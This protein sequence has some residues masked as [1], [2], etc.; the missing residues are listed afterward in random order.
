MTVSKKIA[1]TTVLMTLG[2]SSAALQV[3]A[4]DQV[5]TNGQVTFT[6]GGI[7]PEG[8]ATEPPTNPDQ[9]GEIITPESSPGGATGDGGPLSLDFAP[10]LDFD[11]RDISTKDATYFA[12]VQKG[13]NEAGESV[14]IPN[15][16]QVSDK[17]GTGAGWNLSVT[18]KGQ[19]VTGK[20]KELKGAEIFL[21]HPVIMSSI[22]D[23][24]LSPDITYQGTALFG[25]E[26]ALTP[27]MSADEDKGMGQFQIKFGTLL[28]SDIPELGDARES[29]ILK[30]PGSTVKYADTYTT[31][32]EWTLADIPS[33]H[34]G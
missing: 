16:A 22:A 13:T 26:E 24:T 11:I 1:A 23:Q 19:L 8:G 10:N 7:D 27:L 28:D 15:F 5:T 2:M 21:A 20:G 6:P 30:V 29:V 33:N 31:Q 14:D 17:R 18:Q 9:P 12:K 25:S 34:E 32:L 3:T 4:N